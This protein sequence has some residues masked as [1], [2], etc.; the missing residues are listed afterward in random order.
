MPESNYI[1]RIAWAIQTIKKDDRLSKGIN[2][3]DL[4]K[5]L[6]VSKNSLVKYRR[7]EGVVKIVLVEKLVT[8]YNFSARWLFKGEGEPFT[9]AREK[10]PDVCGPL[11]EDEKRAELHRRA[12]D[13]N[14][15]FISIPYIGDMYSYSDHTEPEEQYVK[16]AFRRGWIRKMGNPEKFI[17]IRKTGDCMM[18][19]LCPG[20]IMLVNRDIDLTLL[21]S[22][23]YVLESK[24]IFTV[25]RIQCEFDARKVK[26]MCDNKKYETVI[27]N[28]ESLKI[29]GKVAWTCRSMEDY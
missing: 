26:V 21:Q 19:T 4:S 16:L 28:I 29:Y 11:A 2:D 13:Y 27:A 23:L 25:R 5:V 8:H 6:S 18:P 1:K 22:G 20:D 14:R 17:V 9:G 12:D 24:N 10:Y 7:G 3:D 15:E